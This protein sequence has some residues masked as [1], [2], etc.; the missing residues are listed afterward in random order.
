MQSE[1]SNCAEPTSFLPVTVRLSIEHPA[2]QTENSQIPGFFIMSL[3]VG[4]CL[5]SYD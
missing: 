1:L 4:N 3:Q 5:I 2:R